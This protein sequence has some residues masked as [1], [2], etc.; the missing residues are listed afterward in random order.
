M[1]TFVFLVHTARQSGIFLQTE[2][3]GPNTSDQK[4]VLG[5]F[6]HLSIQE[7]MA[8]IGLLVQSPEEVREALKMLSSSGQFNMALLFLYGFAFDTG[9][10]ALKELCKAMGVQIEVGAEL[11]SILKEN[12]KVSICCFSI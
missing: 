4:Q 8:M 3:S 11:R 7:F 10:E 9:S 2:V 12:I 6:V 5:E 1:N